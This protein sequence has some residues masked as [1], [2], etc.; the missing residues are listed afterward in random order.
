M[1]P[2]TFPNLN[3][4]TIWVRYPWVSIQMN[5][6]VSLPPTKQV[7]HTCKIVNNFYH[8]FTFGRGGKIVG[9]RGCRKGQGGGG[10]KGW[11]RGWDKGHG[12]RGKGSGI[13]I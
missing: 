9:G 5:F 2:L 1:G 7:P 4:S 6:W 10:K 13:Y 3:I 11:G 12:V 8:R